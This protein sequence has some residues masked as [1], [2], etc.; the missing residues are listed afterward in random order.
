MYLEKSNT[1]AFEPICLC[2]FCVWADWL[3]FFCSK[4]RVVT[5]GKTIYIRNVDPG[6]LA[7]LDELAEQKGISRN[8]FVNI[9]LESFVF[10]DKIKETEEKYSGLVETTAN[11]IN[12]FTLALQQLQQTVIQSNMDNRKD[13]IL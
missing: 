1:R 8:K 6:V 11:A 13:E 4:R 5:I 9:I 7:K 2:T 10:T 3:L 12:N